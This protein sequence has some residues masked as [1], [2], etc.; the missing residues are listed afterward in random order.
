M[1]IQRCHREW[2]K[3]CSVWFSIFMFCHLY[4]YSSLRLFSNSCLKP[5]RQ[6]FPICGLRLEW[7]KTCYG[8]VHFPAGCATLEVC[9]TSWW[10]RSSWGRLSRKDERGKCHFS[11][12]TT[13]ILTLV[14]HYNSLLCYLS[15]KPCVIVQ[16]RSDM[17]HSCCMTVHTHSHTH[18]NHKLHVIASMCV[19]VS[20]SELNSLFGSGLSLLM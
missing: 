19:C 18:T 7:W 16:Q 11:S 8:C 9:V 13:T 10:H 1:K 5:V 4:L 2:M 3:S 14:F 17:R 12:L 6:N 20:F 15:K